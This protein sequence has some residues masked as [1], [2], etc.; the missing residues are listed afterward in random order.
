MLANCSDHSDKMARPSAPSA[1]YVGLNVSRAD[2]RGPFIHTV[3]FEEQHGTSVEIGTVVQAYV[4]MTQPVFYGG[5]EKERAYVI[6]VPMPTL[7]SPGQP[8][9]MLWASDHFHLHDED[10]ARVTMRPYLDLNLN[11]LRVEKK[12]PVTS[13]F[14]TYGFR[15]TTDMRHAIEMIHLAHCGRLLASAQ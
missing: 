7:V 2:R 4:P 6:S 11:N 5:D 14:R 15:A 12:Y 13:L 8:E 10:S 1:L 3:L 9:A